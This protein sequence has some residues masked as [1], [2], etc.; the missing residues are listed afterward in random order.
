MRVT[1]L[2]VL[3]A[4]CGTPDSPDESA[5]ETSD[6]S[7]EI[8]TGNVIP[9]IE[10]TF[11]VENLIRGEEVSYT[12]I[13]DAE[14]VVTV[15]DARVVPDGN[16]VR[17]R[18][19]AGFTGTVVIER[20]VFAQLHTEWTLTYLPDSNSVMYLVSAPPVGAGVEL[21]VQATDVILSPT[22][23][24]SAFRSI[25]SADA[26][27]ESAPLLGDH[28]YQREIDTSQVQVV[29]GP[30]GSILP[31]SYTA[32]SISS[33]GNE[34]TVR[35]L[36][37]SEGAL[38]RG[39]SRASSPCPGG[40]CLD[41][42]AS[43][44]GDY[45]WMIQRIGAE[46]RVVRRETATENIDILDAG[47]LEL[48]RIDDVSVDGSEAVIAGTES[49]IRR[50][51]SAND[52]RWLAGSGCV[53]AP[54]DG[55]TYCAGGND[56]PVGA[57][58]V[59]LPITS[60]MNGVSDT[61][62]GSLS[63]PLDGT[64]NWRLDRL[65]K[66][67]A[68]LRREALSGESVWYIYDLET[69]FLDPLQLNIGGQLRTPDQYAAYDLAE[70]GPKL[71][72]E[73]QDPALAPIWPS[74]GYF[75]HDLSTEITRN[76]VGGD[77]TYGLLSDVGRFVLSKDT[78]AVLYLSDSRNATEEASVGTRMVLHRRNGNAQDC[79]LCDGRTFRD[80]SLSP[81]ARYITAW[82][83]LNDEAILFDRASGQEQVLFQSVSDQ[84]V[85]MQPAALADGAFVAAASVQTAGAIDG[86]AGSSV[87]LIVDA[88]G[89]SCFAQT[90]IGAPDIT[91]DGDGVVFV[92]T[93]AL[94]PADR[95][96]GA[97]VYYWN[98]R[99]DT[100]TW[101]TDQPGET[102]LA[103]QT[104]LDGDYLAYT[105]RVGA[106]TQLLRTR[107]DTY[108][109][110]ELA[111]GPQSISAMAISGSGS[112]VAFI[113]P[114]RDD[115]GFDDNGL[116]DIFT[117]QGVNGAL[118]RLT[119]ME[120]ESPTQ[121]ELSNSGAHVYFDVANPWALVDHTAPIAPHRAVMMAAAKN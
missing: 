117:V 38:R 20:Y 79:I 109:R 101:V 97:D 53:I 119:A 100:F 57:S 33:S 42:V 3:L 80:A 105:M 7:P 6:T 35:S 94:D 28:V 16:A 69:T 32:R 111:S 29:L 15:G 81:R 2:L 48:R 51:V 21:P 68:L 93:D 64:F 76:A 50:H 87:G 31:T 25:D 85:S 44:N 104:S 24:F 115:V 23:R 72:L 30:N 88:Q 99:A 96:G 62:V 118:Q 98:R 84:V 95:D 102:G 34:M 39:T 43:P 121:V 47:I 82:D 9:E 12:H 56:K 78:D 46:Y 37:P 83:E 120:D 103:A 59:Q 73:T 26:F 18:V 11:V 19:A 4:A 86:C 8:H 116:P 54:H 77:I 74:A 67:H 1:G 45:I 49:N 89:V 36:N 60:F 41:A 92:T 27:F 40:E 113:S 22:G 13:E 66:T 91:A 17:F 63:A 106:E 108:A 107:T 75:V 58:F 114:D 14:Y 52:A 65:S 90:L 10:T 112:A 70:I 5:V 61:V 71:L 110:T 55:R